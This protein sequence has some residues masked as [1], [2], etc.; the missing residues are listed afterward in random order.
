MQSA[1]RRQLVEAIGSVVTPQDFEKYMEYHKRKLFR[2]E[3]RPRAFSYAVRRPSCAP[4]GLFVVVAAE[5]GDD[6]VVVGGGGGGGD[7]DDV[8]VVV[9]VVVVAAASCLLVCLF[10]ACLCPVHSFRVVRCTA[11]SQ[12]DL[13]CL[14][15]CSPVLCS[16][17]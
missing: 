4:Q 2:P 12:S 10:I 7:D 6:A 15:V 9:V 11:K 8:V 1:L 3:F 17:H 14:C 16:F 13:L 5:A